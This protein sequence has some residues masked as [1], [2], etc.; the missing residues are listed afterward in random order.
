MLEEVAQL[1]VLDN[2]CFDKAA[3]IVVLDN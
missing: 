3:Q 1:V 2:Y